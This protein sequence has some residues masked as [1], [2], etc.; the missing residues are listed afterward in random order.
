MKRGSSFILLLACFLPASLIK[1]Q[2]SGDSK[3]DKLFKS[4]ARLDSSLFATVY[5]CN[6][7]KAASFFTDDLEFYHDK[8]GLTQSR[9]TF[10]EQLKRN[11]C[12]EANPKLRRELVRGSLKVFP[13]SD[14]GAIQIGD[15]RFYVTEKGQPE[16]LSGE[17]KF[18]HLWKLEN[19]EW[20]ISRVLSFGHKEANS[21]NATVTKE[22]SDT[23][24]HMD[25]LLFEAFNSHDLKKLMA[26]F[27]SDLEFYHDKDGF[28][29]YNRVSEG[30]KRMFDQNN[31]M[32]RELVSGSLEVYPI[33]NYGAIEIG[34]HKFCHVE[35]GKNDCGTFPFIMIW[36]RSAD[37]WKISRVISYNH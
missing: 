26:G 19:G 6:P 4:L 18:A 31:G 30:F 14:Y 7:E 21:N 9:K 12:N 13:L 28:L 25:S 27:T 33:N 22:L 24:A 29:D 20:K 16:R 34:T 5:T 17:A 23:I 15:H 35:N 36:Q 10:I 1:A 37:G 11:F 3:P 8:G 2:T 32:R